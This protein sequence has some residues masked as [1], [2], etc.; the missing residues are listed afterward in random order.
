M[1]TLRLRLLAVFLGCGVLCASASVH[2]NGWEHAAVPFEA[3]LEALAF[4]AAETRRQ[5]A[6]S[7]GFRGQTE[8]VEPLIRALSRPEPDSGVRRAI[9]AALGTLGDPRATDTV[10]YCLRH[11]SRE[12]LRAECAMA[13]GLISDERGLDPLLVALVTD[14]SPVVR[15]RATDALGHFAHPASTN[16]LSSLVLHGPDQGQRLRAIRAL[17]YTG[18]E[19]AVDPLLRRLATSDDDVERVAL[20]DALARLGSH[21]ATAAL[22]AEFDRAR[23][24]ELRAQL[25]MALAATRDGDAYPTLVKMLADDLPGVRYFAI[26]GI[27]ELGR[28]DGAKPLAR[29]SLDTS[30]RFAKRLPQRWAEDPT[31]VVRDLEL[32]KS[33]LR[34]LVELDPVHA[35]P[36][37]VAAAEPQAVPLDSAA[38]LQVAEA[39]YEVRRVALYGLGYTGDQK[40]AD[41]LASDDGVGDEDFRLR[42]TAVRS[43]GVLGS[44]EASEQMEVLLGDPAPEVRWTAAM[45][46]GRLKDVES[47]AGLRD[48]LSDRVAEVR[49]QAALS[50]GYLGDTD[51]LPQLRR[52]A[53]EDE[54]DRVRE[55][56]SLSVALLSP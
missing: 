21:K 4:P 52:L 47:T 31:A 43:L 41:F 32:Q 7:L 8:A 27:R 40:A 25:A 22:Q 29:F 5:A 35:L 48:R 11:E 49:K 53:V 45:V 10:L 42:A 54:S 30:I 55:A 24:P 13:I 50:L 6:E 3:L 34:A 17:G 16:A 26:D 18:T 14:P 28:P 15:Y 9:Y 51:A 1:R 37:F 38:A 39:I 12:E 20:S 23:D 44:P 33:A 56:A 46:L 2:A 19:A 36:A